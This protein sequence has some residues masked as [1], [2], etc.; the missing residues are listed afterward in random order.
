MILVVNGEVVAGSV[1]TLGG[2]YRIG[3]VDKRLHAIRQIDESK[4]PPIH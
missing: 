1:R 2:T 4:L 3:T